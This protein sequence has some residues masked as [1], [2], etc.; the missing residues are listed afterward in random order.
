MLHGVKKFHTISG[1]LVRGNMKSLRPRASECGR[2]G[3]TTGALPVSRV[4]CADSE[5]SR[6]GPL[7]ISTSGARGLDLW[8]ASCWGCRPAGRHPRAPGLASPHGFASSREVSGRVSPPC[9]FGLV[10]LSR[11][12]SH[13]GAQHPQVSSHPA[14]Q[15]WHRK[16]MVAPAASAQGTGPQMHQVGPGNVLQVPALCQALG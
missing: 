10:S 7:R 14:P 9:A 16:R 15:G 13:K 5:E 2:R 4:L 3:L 11:G 6:R 1:I 12:F 8:P